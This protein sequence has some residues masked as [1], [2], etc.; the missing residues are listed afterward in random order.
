MSGKRQ[1]V[2]PLILFLVVLAAIFGFVGKHLWHY[3]SNPEEL[4][5]LV[6][7]FRGWAPFGL[8]F[9]QI[10]QIV[11]A[12]LPGNVAAFVGGYALGFWPTIAWLML[13]VMIGATVAFFIARLFGRQLLKLFLSGKTLERFDSLTLSRGTFYIFLLLLIPNPLG[14]W[15]YYLAGLTGIPFLLFLI[16]VFIARLPSNILECG[17][18]STA[19]RFGVR[20]WL[21]LGGVVV[22]L[23][24]AYYLNQQRIERL[25]ERFSGKVKG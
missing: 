23:T 20:E 6:K 10:I 19:T 25:L 7:G 17:V 3:F 1:A 2:F 11:V 12:P 15:V 21:I 16:L 4:R 8:V 5:L 22:F 24:I 13:G 18:G 14:D 9:L